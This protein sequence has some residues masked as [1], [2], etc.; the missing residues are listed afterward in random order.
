MI[1]RIL[2]ADDNPQ[3]RHAIRHLIEQNPEWHVCGEATDGREAVRKAR[4]LT[5]DLILLDFLM[6]GMN[7][8]EAAR[9]I[10]KTVPEIP[11]LMCTTYMSRQLT[12]LARRSGLRGAV[13]KTG[14][15]QLT[16]GVAA[17]L[18]HETF[19]ATN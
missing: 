6:P 1:A 15:E 3:I 9:E 16:R 7:G 19:F 13:S 18:R 5:P 17:L 8:L 11:M 12:E 14:I 10:S 2:I 4:Q